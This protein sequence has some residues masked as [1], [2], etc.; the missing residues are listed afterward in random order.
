MS[1]I[2][3]VVSL[4]LPSQRVRQSCRICMNNSFPECG[5]SSIWRTDPHRDAE[6]YIRFLRENFQ[7]LV[8]IIAIQNKY[9]LDE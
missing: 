9:E 3:T 6:K 5:Y 7:L 8:I 1:A 4:E 2:E